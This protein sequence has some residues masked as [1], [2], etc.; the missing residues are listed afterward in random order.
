M[1]DCRIMPDV[2]P[3]VVAET[4]EA[5]VCWTGRGEVLSFWFEGAMVEG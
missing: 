4:L 2:W 1:A 3:V 5:G